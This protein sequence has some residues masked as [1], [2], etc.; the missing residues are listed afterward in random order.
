MNEGEMDEL[1][2]RLAWPGI[3][4][5]EEEI[6]KVLAT[7]PEQQAIELKQ[8]IEIA[9]EEFEEDYEEMHAYLRERHEERAHWEE[10]RRETERLCQI[11]NF[12]LGGRDT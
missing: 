4:R 3:H 8:W 7:L 11:I 9:R 5:N 12:P 10:S 6:D 1:S 2:R